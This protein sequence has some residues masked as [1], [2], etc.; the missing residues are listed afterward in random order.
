[1]H[2][3][4]FAFV[5]VAIASLLLGQ[6]GAVA[7]DFPK[8]PI[9][10]VMPWPAGSIT[11]L[12]ARALAKGLSARLSTP[13]VV[14]NRPGASGQIGASFVAKAPADGYTL[15]VVTGTHTLSANVAKDLP[16]DSAKDFVAIAPY[17]INP[18]ALVGRADFPANSVQEVVEV[19][20][21]NPGKFTH[22]SWGIGSLSQLVM[23]LLKADA[24]IDV[25]HVPF[26]GA[27]P[28]TTALVGGQVDLMIISAG[29]VPALA[30]KVKTYAVTTPER[31]FSLPN[32]PTMKEQGYPRV[33]VS[34]WF[35]VLAP[36]KTPDAV[37]Q[38]LGAE[39]TAVI[40]TPEFQTQLHDL[41]LGVHPLMTPPE[42]Q[43]FIV[44]E[45]AR[46]GEVVRRA[47]IPLQ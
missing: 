24:G 9:R 34:S 2:L 21:R 28:A 43:K 25:V 11:D 38:R 41:G 30:G 3:K 26:T 5:V 20:K 35:G 17:A 14:D 33:D 32:T 16:Y 36:A 4:R 10:L 6:G 22:A 23:E 31:F 7:Q 1:M 18:F 15:I 47:K 27:A 13:V 46:W 42:F 29:S 12:S 39:I 40:K 37:V 19:A 8:Q 45:I 44:S